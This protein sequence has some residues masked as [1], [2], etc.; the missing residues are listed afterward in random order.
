[1]RSSSPAGSSLCEMEG[2]CLCLAVLGGPGEGP[3]AHCRNSISSLGSL[4]KL[5]GANEPV[6][7]WIQRLN[8]SDAE[9]TKVCVI[10]CQTSCGL[11]S[12]PFGSSEQREKEVEKKKGDR[13]RETEERR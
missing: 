5:H 11:L 4:G 3:A 13:E 10:S 9:S 1:M 7:R 8:P 6:W 12:G 2:V